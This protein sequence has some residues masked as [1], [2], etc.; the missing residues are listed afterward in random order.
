MSYLDFSI[1][2]DL[3]IPA[4]FLGMKC[5]H[6]LCEQD[7]WRSGLNVLQFE[8]G[9]CLARLRIRGPVSLP[10]IVGRRRTVDRPNH[11]VPQMLPH[12]QQLSC[13]TKVLQNYMISATYLNR[14]ARLDELFFI[15]R[16]PVDKKE[17]QHREVGRFH[18]RSITR[19]ELQFCKTKFGE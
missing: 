14:H 15:H 5:S 4:E 9:N 13:D 3:H 16:L 2:G 12:F 11:I 10:L 17:V 7:T 1:F 19:V 8:S 6:M 18:D